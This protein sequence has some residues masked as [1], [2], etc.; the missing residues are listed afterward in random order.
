MT[1]RVVQRLEVVDVEHEDGERRSQS[2]GKGH[3]LAERVDEEA[4]VVKPGEVVDACLAL[5][6]G[7]KAVA[8]ERQRDLLSR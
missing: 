4:V 1:V 3:L 2:L 7:E 5:H 8:L 6:H